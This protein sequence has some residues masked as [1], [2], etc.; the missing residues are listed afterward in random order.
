M[1][2]SNKPCLNIL[3]SYAYFNK[4]IHKTLSKIDVNH[5]LV[6]DSGAFT[7]WKTGKK[8]ELKDYADFIKNLDIPVWNYFNLDVI[9]EPEKTMN[10]YNELLDK[11]FR[12][13][14]IFTT[15]ENLD[16]L[17]QYY[18]TSEIVALGGLVGNKNNEN[19]VK[20]SMQIIGERK[21]HW[22]GYTR[23]KFVKHYRPI[24]RAH[25]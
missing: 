9:G 25:V 8:I 18:K 6:I 10:N 20:R 1:L 2:K 23:L 11:E 17:E 21:V 24:G 4:K 7:V 3:I 15:G 14:P 12:P 5:K 22:L 16:I 19:I 13:I